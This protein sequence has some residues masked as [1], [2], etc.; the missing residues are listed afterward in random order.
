MSVPMFQVFIVLFCLLGSE[1]AF[2][3]RLYKLQDQYGNTLFS[4]Q[5][6]P[7]SRKTAASFLIT[8]LWWWMWSR[9][10]R[11]KSKLIWI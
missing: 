1:V 11:L 3:K 5:V 2:A 4:D 6:P 10:P 7:D 8:V 9:K